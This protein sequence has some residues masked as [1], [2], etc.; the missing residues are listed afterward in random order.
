MSRPNLARSLLSL[1]AVQGV[2]EGDSLV[3]APSAWTTPTRDG[4]PHVTLIIDGVA[5]RTGVGETVSRGLATPGD[6]INFDAVLGDG[7]A[8]TAQWL[9]PGQFLIVPARRLAQ[10]I[11][12]AALV[13]TTLADLHSRNAGL[14]REV[15]RHATLTVSQ[16]LA[17][18]ILDVHDLGGGDALP[19][20][21]SDLAALM[22]VRRASIST[23]CSELHAAGAIRVRRAAIHVADIDALRLAAGTAH[24]TVTDLARLRG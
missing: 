19:L 11:D 15:L 12:P 14:R 3:A 22:S 24:S 5:A 20:R 4:E 23:A 6:L 21:Q 16:R 7:E 2:D 18:L 17:A 13:E 10:R 9:T 8:E 1:L